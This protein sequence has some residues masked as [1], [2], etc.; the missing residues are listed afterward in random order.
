MFWGKN[1]CKLNCKIIDCFHL[2]IF[3][4]VSAKGLMKKSKED[5]Q[6]LEE[7]NLAHRLSQAK[8]QLVQTSHTKRIKLLL[9]LPHNKRLINRVKSVC[10]GESWPQSCVQTSLR[11]VCTYDLS[12]V[13]I[14]PYGPPS[15]LTRAKSQKETLPSWPSDSE[16]NMARLGFEIFPPRL[17]VLG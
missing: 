5:K 15:R 1:S 8:C 7:L 16:V 12:S 14:L 3:I 2:T 6:I 9:F 13:K 17:N 10:K 4:Y 11:S